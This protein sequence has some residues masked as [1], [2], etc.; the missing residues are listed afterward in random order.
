MDD[1]KETLLDVTTLLARVAPNPCA[2]EAAGTRTRR[3]GVLSASMI[4]KVRATTGS[5]S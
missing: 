4:A 5:I 1:S 3:T 2:T